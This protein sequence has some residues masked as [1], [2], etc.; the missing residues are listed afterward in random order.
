MRTNEAVETKPIYPKI[1]VPT[2]KNRYDYFNGLYFQGKLPAVEFGVIRSAKLGGEVTVATHTPFGVFLPARI[3]DKEN[4][5][6]RKLGVIIRQPIKLVITDFYKMTQ[7]KFDAILLHE[8]AHVWC[9][10]NGLV[11]QGH[12]KVFQSK[13]H[14]LSAKSGLEVPMS[15]S[16]SDFEIS[17]AVAGPGKR[18]LAVVHYQ[19]PETLFILFK[20]SALAGVSPDGYAEAFAYNVAGR[21]PEGARVEL[22][23]TTTNMTQGGMVIAAKFPERKFRFLTAGQGV[24]RSI[25]DG[26]KLADLPTGKPAYKAAGV[27]VID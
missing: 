24:L 1:D 2:I 11:W 4:T 9:A 17:D 21:L 7:D 13:I 18:V 5:D 23:D 10:S 26:K 27:A 8:M 12:G 16:T 3:A 19:G 20:P 22:W 14:E 6:S 15:E 25:T